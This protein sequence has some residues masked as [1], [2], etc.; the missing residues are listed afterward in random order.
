VTP[1]R[2]GAGLLLLLFVATAMLGACLPGGGDA[3]A[4]IPQALVPADGPATR[5]V[6]V[7]PGRGDD[8]AALRAS[9]IAPAVQAAWPDA[10]V[11]LTGLGFAYYMQGR[12]PQRLHQEVIGPA[13]QRGYRE[14]WLVGA[15]MGGMG[16]LMYDRAYPGDAD[17]LILLAPYL[18][19]RSLIDE[20]RAAG[21]AQWQPGPTPAEVDADNYQRELWRHLQSWRHDAGRTGSVWLGYGAQDRLAGA[22][23]PLAELL[24]EDHVL[25]VEGGHAWKV[26]SP[27]TQRM[28]A[29]AGPARMDQR[30]P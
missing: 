20:I 27:L 21:L 24:P 3:R 8:I 12:A 5:L 9:G 6:V 10:D 19:K 16:S 30:S 18:G 29:A 25:V 23:P 11:M 7:L 13:R 14:V 22:M 2:P 28:L 26:W 15:S 4:P 1:S 17:G